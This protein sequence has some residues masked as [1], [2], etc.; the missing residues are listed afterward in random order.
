[1]ALQPFPALVLSYG[2]EAAAN[3]ILA[4][5]LFHAQQLGQHTASLCQAHRAIGGARTDNPN[6]NSMPGS[7]DNMGVVRELN[8][9]AASGTRFA[10]THEAYGSRFRDFQPERFLQ[11]IE[12]SVGMQQFEVMHQTISA[13]E[14]VD[15]LARRYPSA[16]KG[17]VVVGCR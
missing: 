1:M 7:T 14:H 6:T 12:I 9:F 4:D 13:D 17:P 10:D 11:H 15:R 2:L 16:A 8:A 5:D 3:R